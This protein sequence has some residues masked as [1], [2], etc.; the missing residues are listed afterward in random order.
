MEHILKLRTTDRGQEAQL[1]FKGSCTLLEAKAI[2]HTLL[3]AIDQV[4]LLSL[5]LEDIEVVDVSFIQLLCAAHRECFLSAK[6]I[7]IEGKTGATMNTFL[8]T[9]G[10]SKQCGCINGAKK[11]CLWSR[12]AVDTPH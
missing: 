1:F 10:Y 3:E 6:E 8:T 11:S 4:D 9:A 7:Y 2:Q 12:Y 5:D